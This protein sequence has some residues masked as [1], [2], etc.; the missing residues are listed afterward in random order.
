MKKPRKDW[1]TRKVQSLHVLTK[2]EVLWQPQHLVEECQ[3]G[4]VLALVRKL[5]LRGE[6]HQKAQ[7]LREEI[8]VQEIPK[9]LAW[10]DLTQETLINQWVLADKDLLQ[11]VELISNQLLN[12]IHQW[13]RSR[14]KN[15][16][17]WGRNTNKRQMK[18]IISIWKRPGLNPKWRSWKETIRSLWKNSEMKLLSPIENKLKSLSRDI[19]MRGTSSLKSLIKAMMKNGT[20]LRL[21]LIF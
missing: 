8:L 13:P 15:L 12:L 20:L 16:K 3:R 17:N 11:E 7:L 4:L 9:Y 6:P 14:K 19:M 2:L 18:F 10:K 5:Q 1:L 21:S